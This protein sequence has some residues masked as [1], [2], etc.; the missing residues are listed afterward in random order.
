MLWLKV[1]LFILF[2]P[3]SFGL[4]W[5][6]LTL[7]N[8]SEQLISFSFFLFS[9]EQARMAFV[10]ITSYSLGKSNN[11]YNY[12]ILT[13][14]IK[15]ES[16]KVNLTSQDTIFDGENN[17]LSQFLFV[18]IST[19]IIEL[20][21]FYL[22]LFSLGWGAIFVVI[23]LIW[24]NSLAPLKVL[25]TDKFSLT[26]YTFSDKIFILFADFICL[27]L[28]SLWVINFYP[29]TIAFIIL[30]ITLTFAGVKYRIST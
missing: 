5:Q 13:Q 11:S 19:I 28:M 16:Q 25:E 15:Q 27:V 29:L 8:L 18:I 9:L 20:F 24:F 4:L 22:S 2:F 30:F 14:E 21:G 6:S 1:C 17:N 23:S 3:A 12:D 26:N 7:N 10:D